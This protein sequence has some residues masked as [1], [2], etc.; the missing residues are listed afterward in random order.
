MSYQTNHRSANNWW[1]RSP[2]GNNTTNFCNVNSDGSANNNNASNS[3]G[4]AVGFRNLDRSD[5]VTRCG[6]IR[7]FYG[8]NSCNPALWLKQSFDAINRT[9]LAW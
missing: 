6:E 8:R 2:N 4:V 1:E 5:K 9:L 3:N 7:T